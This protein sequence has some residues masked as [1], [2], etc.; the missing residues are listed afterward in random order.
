[1][2]IRRSFDRRKWNEEPRSMFSAKYLGEDG[3]NTLIATIRKETSAVRSGQ[4][5][6]LL[7]LKPLMGTTTE[8]M[9]LGNDDLGRSFTVSGVLFQSGQVPNQSDFAGD[10]GSGILNP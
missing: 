8:G 5:S 10:F 4:G 3:E 1:V 7:R 9:Q 2:F 6:Q